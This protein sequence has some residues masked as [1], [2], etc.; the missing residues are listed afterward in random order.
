MRPS[1][2]WGSEWGQRLERDEVQRSAS[3]QHETFGQELFCVFIWICHNCQEIIKEHYIVVIKKTGAWGCL[4][5]ANC[6]Y[7][8][9]RKY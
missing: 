3:T 8:K 4:G 5:N 9:I 1:P 7:V 2:G 6:H